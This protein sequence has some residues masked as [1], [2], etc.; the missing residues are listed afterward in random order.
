MAHALGSVRRINERD[1][2]RLDPVAYSGTNH[3]GKI[4]I[5]KYYESALL[6]KVGYQ[7]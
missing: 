4:G 7:R 5:E 3:I 2:R 1:A 6:G